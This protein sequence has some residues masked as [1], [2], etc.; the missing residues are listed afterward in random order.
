MG[1]RRF[2]RQ[3][4]RLENLLS[5]DRVLVGVAETDYNAVIRRLVN[6][7]QNAGHLRNPER[8]LSDVLRREKLGA[9]LVGQGLGVPHARTDAVDGVTLALAT[10]KEPVEGSP[11]DSIPVRIV[12]LI[13]APK[14]ESNLYLK[15]LSAVS[16]LVEDEKRRERL[17]AATTPEA[18]IGEIT[19]AGIEVQRGLSVLDLAEDVVTVSQNAPLKNAADTMFKHNLLDV[20]VVDDEGN[21]VGL[22]TA[23]DLLRIGVPD[24]LM[25]LESVAFLRQFEPFEELLRKEETLKVGQVMSDAVCVEADAPLI[26]AAVMMARRDIRTV[27][28]VKDR[29]PVGMISIGDFIRKI[30]RA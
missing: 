22:L 12:V 20:P 2:W 10:T 26:Q 24:Y 8:A 6:A 18:L 3:A 7:L 15:V 1:C 29:K 28:I 19:R 27:I 16:R 13:L 5:P 11:P 17:L 9:T 23:E 4:V 21:L 30:L 25:R 14:A